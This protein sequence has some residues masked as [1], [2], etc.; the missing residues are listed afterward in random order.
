M[1]PSQSSTGSIGNNRAPA[2]SSA[3]SRAAGTALL[4]LPAACVLLPLLVVVW[5]A[6]GGTGDAW[7]RIVE[8]RLWDYLSGTALLLVLVVVLAIA[9]GVACAWLVSAFEFAGR[10][11]LEWLLILPLGV[12]GFVAGAAWLDAFE[13]LAPLFIWVREHLGVEA[14]LLSQR[15]LP[16]FGAVLVL[17]VTLYPYIYMSCRASFAGQQADLIEAARTLGSGP[18]RA[19][20]R[21]VL[22]L[23]RPAIAAGAALVAM[24]TA[25]D[26]GVVTLFGLNTLT[27]GVFRAWSEGS[28]VSAMRL[29]LVLLTLVMF[30]VVLERAQR[31][32]RGYAGDTR[33]RPLARQTLTGGRA[34]VVWLVCGIPLLLGFGWPVLR[35]LGWAATALGT[36]NWSGYGSA[37]FNSAWLALGASGLV[38]VTAFWLTAGRRAYRL[39]GGDAIPNVASLGY[40]LPSALLAVGIGA[41]VSDLARVPGLAW[42]AL[43]ASAV[44]LVFAYW[45]RFLAVG[46]QPVA[47]GQTRVSRD[48]HAAARTLGHSPARALW[49]VD[50]KLLMPAIAAAAILC[51]VDVFKELTLTLVMR[52]FDFETLATLT[53]RLSSE[54]RIPEAAL[55]AL[56][57]ISGGM[58]GVVAMNRL[59][60]TTS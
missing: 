2:L 21:I 33:E 5:R 50:S 18:G 6:A 38:V 24:E 53:F 11:T 29:A 1:T 12:P 46:I 3:F 27:P 40:A 49:R 17:V 15:I 45:V 54:G 30:V 59:L 13:R 23:A 16:W 4:W 56:V 26:Y 9:V 47:G 32:R 39:P 14:F 20:T 41:L 55:P 37:L 35:F 44:G 19:F 28:L 31:G 52:P 48:L 58:L 7:A 36:T 8:Y 25:N 42:L 60:R 34:V 57:L 51:F 10:R 43:S 22:P